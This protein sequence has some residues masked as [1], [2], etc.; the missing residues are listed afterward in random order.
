METKFQPAAVE[1]KIYRFWE[2]KGLLKGKKGKPFTI[3]MP[4]PN[5]NA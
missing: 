3:L 4:P 1:E 5:A 2:K